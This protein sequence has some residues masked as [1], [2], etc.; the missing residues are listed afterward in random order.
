MGRKKR[1]SNQFQHKV[2]VIAISCVIIM[3]GGILF[4]GSSSL[5]EKN[6]RYQA[7]EAELQTQLNQENERKEELDVMEEYVGTVEHIKEVAKEKCGLVEE[8]E[9]WFKAE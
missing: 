3:L 2:S 4:I 5:R 7:Q 9:I 6:A 1:K 8:G